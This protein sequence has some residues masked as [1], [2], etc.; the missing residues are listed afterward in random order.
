MEQVRIVTLDFETSG[1][2]DYSNQPIEVCLDV[3]E[4]NGNNWQYKD[5]IKLPWRL[6]PR[7]SAINNITNDMLERYGRPIEEVFGNIRDILFD[8]DFLLVGHYILRFDNLFLNYFLQKFF[9]RRFQVQ[10]SQCWD[11]CAEM[12]ASLLGKVFPGHVNG[13]I[14]TR[15]Q[16]HQSVLSMRGKYNTNTTA[17]LSDACRYY[18][19]DIKEVRSSLLS[20]NENN[21]HTAPGDVMRTVAIFNRQVELLQEQQCVA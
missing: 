10:T 20:Y 4:I 16:W 18:G 15:G 2:F 8:Q 13:E 6:S 21:F 1:P 11:T 19:V 3:K 5:F 17:T 12:R 14:I 9:T 7:I